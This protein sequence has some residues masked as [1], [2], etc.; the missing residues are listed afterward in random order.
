MTPQSLNLAMKAGALMD[1]WI[2][3]LIVTIVV[4]ILSAF[5]VI[6]EFSL[7][8]ARRNRLEE[9]AETSRASRAGLRSLNELTIMLAGAQLALPPLPSFWVR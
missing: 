3:N 5:F 2:V 6:I 1:S 9:T 7:M 8:S 4:I